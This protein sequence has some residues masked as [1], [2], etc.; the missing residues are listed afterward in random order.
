MW[1]A[2][3]AA[4]SM[5][6]AAGITHAQGNGDQSLFHVTGKAEVSTA[7]TIIVQNISIQLYGIDAPL[8]IQPCVLH[9]KPWTCGAAALEHLQALVAKGPVTCTQYKDPYFARR[10]F[11]WGKCEV[12]GT[13]IS[14]EMVR[15]GWAVA[16]PEQTQDYVPL[17]KA[18]HDAKIGLWEADVFERPSDWEFHM[19]TQ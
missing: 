16:L 7:D 2:S 10:A 9:G 13:D 8:P 15:T 17:E 14:A 4:T 5:L 11:T 1:V 18:A 3:L 12:D 19:R 6:T